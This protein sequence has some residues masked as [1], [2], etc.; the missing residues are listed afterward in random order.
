MLQ[1]RWHALVHVHACTHCPSQPEHTSILHMA[2]FEILLGCVE[3]RTPSAAP[4]ASRM[5]SNAGRPAA[6]N[7]T[8]AMPQHASAALNQE[9]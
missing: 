6:L 5:C 2:A 4:V 1:A 8:A 3:V 7:R 9:S